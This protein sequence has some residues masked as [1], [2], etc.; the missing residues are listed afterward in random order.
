MTSYVA[1]LRGVNLMGGTT[2]RMADLKAIAERLGLESPRTFIAS[3]NLLF[4]SKKGERSVKSS[5]EAALKTHMSRDVG[6]MVRTASELA[7]VASANPFPDEPGNKVVAIFLD[8]APP[9]DALKAAKN[10]SEER[11]TLGKREIYVHYPLG[12]G[13]SRLT[14]PAAARGTARNMN[15]VAKLVELAKEI[16]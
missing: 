9:A 7:A 13:L 16:S 14:I 3:G 12:Q 4:A 2:L 6:V 15:T 1:L 10:V 5:L 8:E 11:M